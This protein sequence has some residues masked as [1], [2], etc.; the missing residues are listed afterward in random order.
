MSLL[1]MNAGGNSEVRA[2]VQ[3]KAMDVL[4][5]RNNKTTLNDLPWCY[6]NNWA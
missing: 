4:G 6:W 2:I 5:V 1:H 3:Y